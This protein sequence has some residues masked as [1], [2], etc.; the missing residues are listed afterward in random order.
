MLLLGDLSNGWLEKEFMRNMTFEKMI[1]F[2]KSMIKL[3]QKTS[4]LRF[5][6]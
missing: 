5:F 3:T 2:E 1:K 6:L 4:F